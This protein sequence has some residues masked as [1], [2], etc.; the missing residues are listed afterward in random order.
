MRNVYVL[1]K[2]G[3]N[4]KPEGL[5]YINKKI[6]EKANVR[7]DLLIIYGSDFDNSE[8]LAEML[9]D[10]IPTPIIVVVYTDGSLI[11]L[12]SEH[13]IGVA[14]NVLKDNPD[15]NSWETIC[16]SIMTY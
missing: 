8:N 7:D 4:C 3:V 2:K 5:E 6:L 11:I 15:K 12:E 16:D 1:T 13:D 14:I 9:E 10:E